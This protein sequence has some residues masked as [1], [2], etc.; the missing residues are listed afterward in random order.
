MTSER[1][2]TVEIA[3]TEDDERTR[4]DARLHGGGHVLAGWGRARRNPVDRDVPLVGEELAASRALSD[5]A[6]Q[7][8]S[9]ALDVVEVIE[10]E[11][12]EPHASSR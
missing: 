11:R 10:A 5:L 4:A 3:F 12:H 6:R 2:W 1:V 9:D 7:L 8:D